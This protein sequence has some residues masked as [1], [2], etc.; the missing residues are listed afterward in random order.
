MQSYIRYKVIG[1]P[2]TES[3]EINPANCDRIM[4]KAQLHDYQIGKSKVMS[5]CFTKH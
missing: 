2:V 5:E 3:V 1:F 4:R